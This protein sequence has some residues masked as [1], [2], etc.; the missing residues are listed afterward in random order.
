MSPDYAKLKEISGK[1]R[2][3]ILKMGLRCGDDGAHF[4]GCFSIVDLFAFLF[5]QKL[6]LPRFPR[7]EQRDRVVLSKGHA[8]IALYAAMGQAGMLPHTYLDGPMLGE[9]TILY[10]HSKRNPDYGI[11]MSS[12][13]LG[14]GLSFAVGIAIALKK[15]GNTQ[16]QVYVFVGEGEC[17]EGSIWE[18]AELA[19]HMQ[20]ENLTVIVD[21]NGL[22]ID[23]DTKDIINLQNPDEQWKAFGFDTIVIDG[24]SFEEINMAFSRFHKKPLA[25]I[26]NT[27]K[28][29]GVSFIENK[30]EWH[31]KYL[32]EHMYQI[33]LQELKNKYGL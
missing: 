5:T 31:Q 33:A 22:Q 2:L 4:G 16:S 6:Q 15:K 17:Q 1:M 32:D 9:N 27:V 18:A 29:K 12:G 3:D 10:K 23:G 26:A 24:H 7:D 13:S 25:I 30:V 11:E 28:G 14:Q 8:S 19:G 20:L 21:K